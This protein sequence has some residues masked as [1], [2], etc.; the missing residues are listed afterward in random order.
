MK[1]F[2]CGQAGDFGQQAKFLGVQCLTNRRFSEHPSTGSREVVC[3]QASIALESLNPFTRF[4]CRWG[5]TMNKQRHKINRVQRLTHGL[6]QTSKP[7]HCLPQ[8]TRNQLPMTSL[9][10]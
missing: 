4:E 5:W 2:A 8:A 9:M 1:P 3:H 6:D 7:G 10:S